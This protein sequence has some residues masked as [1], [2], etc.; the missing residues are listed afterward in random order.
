ML[1]NSFAFLGFFPLV[2]LVYFAIP[3]KWR[4]VWL[5]LGSYYFY[6]CWNPVYILLLLFST[7]VSYAGGRALDR[8]GGR[9]GRKLI[10]AGVVLLHVGLLFWYKYLNF[11]LYTCN[12]LLRRLGVGFQWPQYDILLPVGISF[13][14]FQAMGYVIDVYRK[15]TACEKNI[16]RYALFVSFFPQLVAGPIER[17]QNLMHQLRKT[18]RFDWERVKDGLFLMVW[19]YFLK[20]VLADRAALVVN[21]I[22]QNPDHYKGLYMVIATV[23]FLFQIYGDFA[24]YSVIA[25]GAAKVL[26]I[27]LMD[28]F[29]APFFAQSVSG[30]WRDWHISL[31]TWFRD[32]VYIPLGGS[33]KG[34]L[35]TYRNLLVVFTLSGLWHGAAWHYV[36]W[37]VINGLYQ[38]VGDIW[39]RKTAGLWPLLRK[40][41]VHHVLQTVFTFVLVDF[42]A[43]FFRAGSFGE[44]FRM[45]YSAGTVH[46]P[47][48]FWNGEL[49][50]LLPAG[51]WALLLIA[52][53]L[54]LAVQLGYRRSICLTEWL[55]GRKVWVRWGVCMALLWTV[56]MFG[57]YGVSYEASAFIYF[58]F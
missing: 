55:R 26:G 58:Q 56:I 5:L 17:S 28:N 44:A 51:E 50:K 30:F 9:K 43:L 48:I 49:I 15:D 2:V 16:F 32:Y 6:M 39:K 38:I 45:L 53:V 31:T 57:I 21:G 11:F 29:R 46:N 42:S 12:Q 18:H 35:L 52:I 47:E 54:A 10:L 41:R 7:V 8:I 33:R 25:Q 3:L 23:L 20:L 37:G 19:G 40:S 1:F 27:S 24:G 13:F 14:T 4:W 36:A 34:R 22:W